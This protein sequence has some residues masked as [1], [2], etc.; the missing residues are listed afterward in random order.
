MKTITISITV[1]DSVDVQVNQ[2]GVYNGGQASNRPF[3]PRAD[4]P[5]PGGACPVHGSDWRL[6]PGGVSKKTGRPYNGF[7]TC[8]TQGCDQKPGRDEVVEL[9]VPADW[10]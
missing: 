3:V 10:G 6:V 5:Q 8:S 9:E 7:W 4:P 2:G 1:P